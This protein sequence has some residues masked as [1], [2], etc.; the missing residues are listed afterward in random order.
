MG[1]GKDTD[2]GDEPIACATVE[3]LGA[4]MDLVLGGKSELMQ[5]GD[6]GHGTGSSIHRRVYSRLTVMDR[7][8]QEALQTF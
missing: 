3:S 5:P 7:T 8:D 6:K 4:W 2:R 1:K